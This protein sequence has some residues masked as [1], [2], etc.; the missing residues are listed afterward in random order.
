MIEDSKKY[1]K[2]TE[3]RRAI[4]LAAR[5]I[6]AEKGLDGLR[7]RAVAD[8]VGINI[9][10][11]H[12]HVKSKDDL[13]ILVAE[14]IR[15]DFIAWHSGHPCK[16]CSAVEQLGQEFVEFRRS[17][18]ENKVLAAALAELWR[19]ASRD[20]NVAR[21]MQPLRSVWYAHFNTL[22]QAGIDE[23]SYRADLDVDIFTRI[24]VSTLSYFGNDRSVI[25]NPA[26]LSR[27]VNELFRSIL[28]PSAKEKFNGFQFE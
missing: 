26:E 10:T 21:H 5:R 7:M 15:D 25:E 4:A 1:L 6:I 14:A 17:R 22:L 20:S 9:A 2:G 18:L 11:L 28:T 8:A 24:I 12:Y 3:R 13:L 19:H 16:D 27:V 23:G